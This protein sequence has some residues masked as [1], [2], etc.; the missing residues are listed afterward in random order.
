MQ[1]AQL[2]KDLATAATE[3][4]KIILPGSAEAMVDFGDK[5]MF[6]GTGDAAQVNAIFG[7]LVLGGIVTFG[8]SVV[9]RI[10]KKVT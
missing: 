1:F 8:A 2:I 9:K 10:A 5:L 3:A 4:A 6:S 7:M